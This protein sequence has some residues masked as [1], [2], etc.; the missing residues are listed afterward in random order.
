MQAQASRRC[1]P[2]PGACGWCAAA[3]SCCPRS[4]RASTPTSCRTTTAAWS[5]SSPTKALSAWSA[6]PTCRTRATRRTAR[7]TAE[8]AAYLCAA[9]GRQFRRAPTAGGDRLALFRRA[10]APR[11]R[12]RRSLRRVPRLCRCRWTEAAD[13]RRRRSRC[14]AARSPPIAASRRRRWTGSASVLGG[15]GARTPWTGTAPLP[16]GDLGG[17]GLAAFERG[18]GRAAPVAAAATSCAGWR[19]PTAPNWRRC[20]GGA[21]VAGAIWARISA[22]ASPSGSW[23]GSGSEEWARTAEDV[24]WRRTRLGLHLSA[25]QREAVAERL[26]ASDRS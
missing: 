13:G 24:L 10:P 9:V 19:V 5:S 14:S 21:T 6:P 25:S 26:Q 12:R 7:C 23:S 22:A 2:P 17:L 11:R 3:T 16:G 20:S 4:T 1:A 18:D 15:G 8:E